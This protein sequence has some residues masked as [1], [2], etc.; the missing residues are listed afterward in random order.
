MKRVGHQCHR[1]GHV[2][3]G[4][5]DEEEQRGQAEHEHQPTS[6]GLVLLVAVRVRLVFAL[7]FAGHFG[8]FLV[9]AENTER[10][11]CGW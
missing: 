8:G 4:D 1:V 3:D 9:G 10:M 6:I 2:A 7:V 11:D 5:L